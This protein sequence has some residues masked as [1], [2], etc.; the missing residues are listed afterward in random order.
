MLVRCLA[1]L[2]TATLISATVGAVL[3][4]ADSTGGSAYAWY[5]LKLGAGGVVSGMDIA[6][7]G[8]KV[9]RTDTYGAYWFNPAATNC[10]ATN[11]KGC[12]QQM[13]TMTSMP[14]GDAGLGV[15]RTST[16]GVYA[17]GIAASN[18]KH[19]YMIFNGY[20]YSSANRGMTWTR[21]TLAQDASANPNDDFRAYN[22]KLAID[23]VDENVVFVSTPTA[24]VSFSAN[25]GATWTKI[26]IESIAAATG[27]VGYLIA[28][29]PNSSV[30]GGKTQG[31]YVS[32]Q[33]HGVYHSTDGGGSWTLTTGA[34]TTHQNMNVD[35]DG[36]VWLVDNASGRGCGAL[37]KYDGTWANA[38]SNSNCLVASAVNPIVPTRVYAIQSFSGKLFISIDRGSSF[39]G[40]TNNG[41]VIANDV[42]WL[43]Q[44]ITVLSNNIGPAS[45]LAF[46]PSMSN[47]LYTSTGLGVMATN[48]PTSAKTVTW[49]SQSA[50]IEQLVGNWVVSPNTPGS[51]PVV[52]VWDQGQFLGGTSAY[53]SVHIG[54]SGTNIPSGW[55]VDWASSSP[56]T[57]VS[58]NTTLSGT[59]PPSCPSVTSTDTSSIS[60]DGGQT[61]R[62]FASLPVC[63]GIGIRGGSIAANSPTNICVVGTDNGGNDNKLIC[64]QNGG[65][66]WA[67]AKYF[68]NAPN[69]TGTTGWGANYFYWTQRLIADRGAANTFYI[70]NDGGGVAGA[71]G[72]WKSSDGGVNW[73]LAHSG[74]FRNSRGNSQMR[75]VPGRTGNFYYT[76]GVQGSPHPSSN[77]F[78]ECTDGGNL[79]CT[80]VANVKE[81][82]SVGFGLHAPGQSY[83]AI[84]IVGW[85]DHGLGYTYG[86]WRSDDHHVTWNL[87]GDGFPMGSFDQITTIE[88]DNN[89]YGTCYIGFRGSGFVFGQPRT[90]K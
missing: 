89:A 58:L 47:M 72:I 17:I 9:V 50:G 19:F 84:Y 39:S 49:I 36:N 54:A 57:I 70:Y 46:D 71:A 26:G 34:P 79:S 7:D 25:A 86:V 30:V 18:T 32:S 53:P 64:T 27:G 80:G 29:D 77:L 90:Q 69:T 20:V 78:Y 43:G 33:G 87:I 42:P 11:T 65:I 85:V 67:A 44:Q 73:T 51:K 59:G 38:L 2:C 56:S 55:S 10:G 6:A 37:N 60:T 23:P 22:Q 83:P 1:L 62:V 81:V 31:L 35:A 52:G 14:T 4:N 40:A 16:P 48:P 66:S 8:T 88:G 75:A 3:S 63:N 12:W 28:F 24:G 74:A 61:G 76:S 5:P 45:F 68:G 41:T 21:G 82:W 13:V 15:V